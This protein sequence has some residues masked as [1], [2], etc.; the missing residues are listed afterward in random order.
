MIFKKARN[1]SLVACVRQLRFGLSTFRMNPDPQNL[2]KLTPF[3][4]AITQPSRYSCETSRPPAVKI[5][6]IDHSI[7]RNGRER[8]IDDP[9]NYRIDRPQRYERF[10]FGTIKF[11]NKNRQDDDSNEIRYRNCETVTF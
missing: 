10:H 3:T 9:V 11:S 5:L 2:I 6:Q 7:S 4:R 8:S 1:S